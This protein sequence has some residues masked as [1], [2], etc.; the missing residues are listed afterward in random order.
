MFNRSALVVLGLLLTQQAVAAPR[1]DAPLDSRHQQRLDRF[2]DRLEGADSVEE[3]REMA[4]QKIKPA[5][6]VLKKAQALAP[7]DAGLAEAQGRLTDFRADVNGAT[8]SSQV[9]SQFRA[10]QTGAGG[11]DMTTGEVIA[12][13]LGFILGILPGI[14]LLILLC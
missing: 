14:I 7:R 3:A 2:A 11:C 4:L 10:I 8:S 12:T 9:A 5:A 1:C 13:V 6:S